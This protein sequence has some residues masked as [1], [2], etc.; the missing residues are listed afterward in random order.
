MDLFS[1]DWSRFAFT[2]IINFSYNLFLKTFNDIKNVVTYNK[3]FLLNFF[4]FNLI[5]NYLTFILKRKIN[6]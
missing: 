6:I 4:L 1:N 3:K 5:P 2:P